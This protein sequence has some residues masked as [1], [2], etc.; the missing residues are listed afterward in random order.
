MPECG[1]EQSSL[2]KKNKGT[3]WRVPPS[4]QR[5]SDFAWSVDSLHVHSDVSE[6]QPFVVIFEIIILQV[7]DRVDVSLP[8][9]DP[10]FDQVDRGVVVR[11]VPGESDV[12]LSHVSCSSYVWRIG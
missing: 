12:V 9:V 7:F 1:C 11:N 8:L 3:G 2:L 6:R 10:L 5:S 4:P